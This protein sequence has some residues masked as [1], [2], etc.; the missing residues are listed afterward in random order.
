MTYAD[1]RE[2]LTLYVNKYR[3]SDIQRITKKGRT[4]IKRFL[5]GL[6]SL[7]DD[8]FET[9]FE[10]IKRGMDYES[11]EAMIAAS[12]GHDEGTV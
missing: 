12:R 1:K 7:D 2:I 9:E 8:A 4:A 3:I 5:D 10:K 11:I 6:S